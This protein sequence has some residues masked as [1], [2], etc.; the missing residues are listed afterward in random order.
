MVQLDLGMS[1]ELA[2]IGY[3]GRK[4]D[5]FVRVLLRDSVARVIDVRAHASSHA[6]GFGKSAIAAACKAAGIEYLHLKQA[7]NPFRHEEGGSESILARYG[8]HLDAH[9]EVVDAVIAAATGTRAALLCFEHAARDCHRSVLAARV[10]ARL[11][12]WRIVDI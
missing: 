6:P 11:P 10:Q 2:T 4:L 7:G 5:A 3:Q 1:P 9:P 8:A 12:E